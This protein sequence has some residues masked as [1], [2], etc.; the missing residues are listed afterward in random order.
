MS[1]RR[2]IR[3]PRNRDARLRLCWNRVALRGTIEADTWEK[4]HDSSPRQRRRIKRRHDPLP[5][6]RTVDARGR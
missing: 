4:R 1:V 6:L 2:S 5:L 3:K